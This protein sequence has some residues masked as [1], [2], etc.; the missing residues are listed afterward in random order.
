MARASEI[1]FVDRFVHVSSASVVYQGEDVEAGDEDLPYASRS[2]A[3]YADS[4]IAAEK[5]VIAAHRPG[6]LRTAAIRPHVVFGPGDIARAH[7]CDEW[8]ALDEV[9]QASEILY[10]LALDGG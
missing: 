3:P 10:R 8:V 1:L 7:T 4:K 6:G 5:V 9:E 2:Q